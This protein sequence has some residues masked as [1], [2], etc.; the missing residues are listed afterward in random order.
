M[1][2]AWENIHERVGRSRRRPRVGRTPLIRSSALSEASGAEIYLKL[3]NL[4]HTNSFKVRGAFNLVLSLSDAERQRGLVAASTGNHGAAVAYV[5]QQLQLGATIVLPETATPH[6][7]QLCRI[8]GAEVRVEGATYDESLEVASELAD[9]ERKVLVPATE[10]PLVMA[11]QGT[12]AMEILEERPETNVLIVPVGGGGLIVGMAVWAKSVRPGIRI[13]GAQ[14]SGART[15]YES[16]QAGR[17]VDVPPEPTLADAL[18]GGIT[19][20]NLALVQEHVDEFLLVDEADLARAIKWIARS[21]G[22]V[23]EGAGAVG[24]AALL[25]GQIAL[26]AGEEAVVLISG[27]NIGPTPGGPTAVDPSRA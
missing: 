20:E 22:Q 13:I 4:Q 25:Q 11:G 7:V 26:R 14:S 16:L 10:H 21:E 17:V 3:E 23:I 2:E 18:A 24:V 8:H 12:I 1:E 5:A 19:S 9:R 15:M 27:G 6:K